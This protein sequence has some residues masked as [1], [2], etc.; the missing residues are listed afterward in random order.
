MLYTRVRAANSVGTA[1][2]S[3]RECA[4]AARQLR[5]GLEPGLRYRISTLNTSSVEAAPN[6]GRR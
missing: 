4:N 1:A 5:K 3:V 2:Q 6:H